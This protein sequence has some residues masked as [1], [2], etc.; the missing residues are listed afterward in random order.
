[1]EYK[2]THTITRYDQELESLRA[3]MGRMGE[4]VERQTTKA[5]AAV[6]DQ[7]EHA[8]YE[9]SALDPQVDAL[10]REVETL[11]IRILALRAPMASDLRM[12]IAALKMSSDLERIGDYAA[13]IAHRSRKATPLDDGFSFSSLRAMGHM[14]EENLHRTVT[15]MVNN[16]ADIACEVWSSDTIIDDL[17][18]TM[19][20]ELVT[21]MMETPR[22]IGICIHLLVIAKNLERIG[23][24]ATNIAERIYYAV[25]GQMLPSERPRGGESNRE[26]FP[27]SRAESSIE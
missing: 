7:D 3:I 1:M 14:V 17:Y 13:S 12:I 6:V 2:T 19:F 25:T 5:V 24:H 4:L 18:T 9:A 15:A 27:E 20:R 16:D 23:D 21:Y 8:A 26:T 10:E 11:G 22:H